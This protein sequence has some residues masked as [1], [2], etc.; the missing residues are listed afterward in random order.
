MTS[1]SMHVASYV[2]IYA[3][4]LRN[5]LSQLIVSSTAHA[6]RSAISRP[7]ARLSYAKMQILH[8]FQAMQQQ[9]ALECRR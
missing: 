9:S 8:C 4:T 1:L 3:V 2:C 6:Q 5:V 7:L